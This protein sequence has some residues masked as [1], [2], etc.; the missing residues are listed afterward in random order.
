MGLLILI[1]KLLVSLEVKLY[2]IL[3]VILLHRFH[4]RGCAREDEGSKKET[5]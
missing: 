5:H 3:L 2:G 1:I 4:R